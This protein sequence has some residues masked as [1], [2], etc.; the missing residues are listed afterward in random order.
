MFLPLREHQ[1]FRV[2]P[3]KSSRAFTL[4]ELL[5]VIAIIGVLVALLLPAVQAAREAA[6]RMKCQNN[7]K[8]LSLAILN[9][10]DT[11][12]VLPPGC[13]KSNETSWHVHILPFIE[14]R[15]L[16]EKFDFSKGDYTANNYVGRGANA[17][18]K[19]PAFLCP[20]S[21][22]EKMMQPDPPNHI[23]APDI[24]NGVYPY[25]THYYM[26]MGPKGQSVDGQ[27]YE[28][29]N[30]GQGGFSQQGVCEVD[31]RYKLRDITDGTSFT[32]LLG[33]NSRHDPKLGSRFRSWMRGCDSNGKDHICGCR[34]FVNGINTPTPA[35]STVFNDIAM[36]SHHPGG[37]N[38]SMCDGTVRFVSQNIN[39]GVYK[40]T[41][42]RNG[43]ESQTVD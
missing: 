34:N 8:Q 17:L 11:F 26:N 43:G 4:V 18:I 15:A 9:Y 7:M 25:T 36:G 23:N 24:V 28:L 13:T 12:Q 33:E 27:T 40:S 2:S 41:S 22:A 39:L 10:H 1:R 38:F 14:Q 5:V 6:R 30:E 37:A 42:S 19:V 20:S 31:S 29:R 35:L 21:P 16:Y 3:L 32:F